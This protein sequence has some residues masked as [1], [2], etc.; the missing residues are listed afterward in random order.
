VKRGQFAR[1]AGP[2]KGRYLPAGCAAP[3]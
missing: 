2:V 1:R 3:P